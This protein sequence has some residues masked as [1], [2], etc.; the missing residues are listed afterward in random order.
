MCAA[1]NTQPTQYYINKQTNKR[2]NLLKQSL[3]HNVRDIISISGQGTKILHAVEQLLSLGIATGVSVHCNT[4][5][6]V[7]LG[8]FNIPQIRPDGAKERKYL[9]HKSKLT[10]FYKN[11]AG[12]TGELHGKE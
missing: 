1:A 10:N 7:T 8:C 5:S 2:M 12:K 4:R 6:H 3:P 11:G 9:F